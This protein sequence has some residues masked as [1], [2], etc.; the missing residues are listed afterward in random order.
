[1]HLS[2]AWGGYK[3]EME[4]HAGPLQEGLLGDPRRVGGRAP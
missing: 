3:C 1:M 2:S 4:V